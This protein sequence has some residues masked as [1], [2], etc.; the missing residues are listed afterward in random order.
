MSDF[1]E[2]LAKHFA[3]ET[4][5]AEEQQV[6]EWKAAN[7]S[8]YEMLQSS[9]NA[10]I[11]EVHTYDADSAWNKMDAQIEEKKPKVIR[12][13]LYRR[14][15]VAASVII[16]IGVGLMT[17]F[18]GPSTQNIT[19]NTA[20]V[21]DVELPDGSK[22]A[23]APD[24]S[25]TYLS[26]FEEERN[27]TLDGLAFFEVERD[28]SHPFVVETNVGEVEVLGTAFNVR[29]EDDHT[30]VSVEHGLVALRNNGEEIKL[31][32]DEFASTTNDG[33]SSRSTVDVNF[34]SWKTGVFE[35]DATPLP[36]VVDLLNDY[37]ETD[38]VLESQAA[39]EIELT[40]TFDKFTFDQV[41][42]VIIATSGL[43]S[44][45]QEGQVLLK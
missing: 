6:Q 10:E 19:N 40:A 9:W 5:P 23:L 4:S 2:I 1:N 38:I 30:E 8:E 32:K 29:N 35:F 16:L 13:Q 15:A 28:E 7:S 43:E 25:L 17:V 41:L 14:I 33:V 36:E 26:N 12:M 22:V 31:G 27:I 21:M 37:Y 3:G 11:T 20:S 44:E 42:T 45:E 34:M 24:A 18:S 39:R